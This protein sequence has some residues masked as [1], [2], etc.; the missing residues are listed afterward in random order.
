MEYERDHIPALKMYGEVFFQ[1]VLALAPDEVG[2]KVYAPMWRR[3]LYDQAVWLWDLARIPLVWCS[4]T[5]LEV[6]WKLCLDLIVV[7]KNVA[8]AVNDSVKRTEKRHSAG[9]TSDPNNPHY[10]ARCILLHMNDAHF[11]ATNEWLDYVR[12]CS[13]AFLIPIL[14]TDSEQAFECQVLEVRWHWSLCYEVWTV[15]P[16]REVPSGSIH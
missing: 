16:K 15:L 4:A 14:Y 2:K 11:L 9:Q 10:F 1:S 5:A 6:R 7:I 3:D 8:Q 12:T 13:L